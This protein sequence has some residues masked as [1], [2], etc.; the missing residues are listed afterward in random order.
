M[1]DTETP[2][3]IV[4]LDYAESDAMFSFLDQV[5]PE[6]LPW[7]KIGLQMFC[8]YGPSLVEEV[9]ARGYKIFLDLKLHDIPNTVAGAVKSL[10]SLPISM[11]TLQASGGPEMMARAAE[12]QRE[13]APDLRLLAVTVLT[14]MNAEQLASL[15]VSNS[16]EDQVISL[17]G[18]AN[19]SG[20]PGIVCSANEV[21]PIRAKYG[22]KPYLVT[23][24]IRLAG[25]DLQDQKRAMTPGKA[26]Q[27]GSNA[28]VVGR[29]ITQAADPAAA[30]LAIQKEIEESLSAENAS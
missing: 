4:A 28:L 15:G 14:S 3:C 12:V 19:D 24:G 25:G 9:G 30:C 18:M 1:V 5:T 20:V 26:V 16:V 2:S 23:P 6:S 7:V 22:D 29:P 21:A 13:L 10:T 27:A 8:K 11:L 17:V